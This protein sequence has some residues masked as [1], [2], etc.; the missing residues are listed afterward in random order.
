MDKKQ[1]HLGKESGPLLGRMPGLSLLGK[2]SRVEEMGQG[3][4]HPFSTSTSSPL[5]PEAMGVR[6]AGREWLSGAWGCH[7]SPAKGFL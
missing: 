6:N 5:Y 4:P 3:S 2:C 1:Q 7:L